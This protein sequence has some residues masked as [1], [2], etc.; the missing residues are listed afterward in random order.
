MSPPYSPPR[1]G[2]GNPRQPPL[3]ADPRRRLDPGIRVGS[4]TPA[5]VDLVNEMWTYG[6]NARSR[7][8]LAEV[9]GR[10]PSLCLQ[11]EAGQ[12]LCWALTDPF[13]TSTHG[14]TLPAHRRRG[15]MRTV[16]VLAA[17]QAQARGFPIFGHTA[18]GNQPM[19]RLQEELG[20]RRLPGLCRFV[21][22][23][24]GLGRV[25]S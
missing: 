3:M 11:D 22:H 10:F 12:P 6:G 9:L 14:Y 2:T 7:Q 19:Q 5:H 20:H 21:L 16:L 25:G 1:P 17:H 15:Y 4:L 13:G 18:M 8:Y 23:N 24:P